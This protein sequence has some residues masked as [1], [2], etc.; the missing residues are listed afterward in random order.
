MVDALRRERACDQVANTPVSFASA[1]RELGFAEASAFNRAFRRWA[2]QSPGQWRAAAGG[3]SWRRVLSRPL[4]RF[5]AAQLKL[6]PSNAELFSFQQRVNL[7][8]G[9]HRPNE[10]MTVGAA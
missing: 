1:T 10:P 4:S 5:A 2:G 7:V 3:A 9:R 8:A 6:L